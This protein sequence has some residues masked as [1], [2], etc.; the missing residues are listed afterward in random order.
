[1]Y[2]C[3]TSIHVHYIIYIYIL[4]IL[5]YFCIHKWVIT[6]LLTIDPKFNCW[7]S[8]QPWN[9]APPIARERKRLAFEILPMGGRK[10]LRWSK[11]CTKSVESFFLN[12]HHL[13]GKVANVDNRKKKK[14]KRLSDSK[15]SLQDKSSLFAA[16]R[17]LPRHSFMKRRIIQKP[18]ARHRLLVGCWATCSPIS[19]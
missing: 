15:S 2:V 14:K 3:T 11:S 9:R 19:F 12:L 6:L 7:T 18:R 5:F 1:M 17:Q 10:L 8:G 16:P 4:N 13:V